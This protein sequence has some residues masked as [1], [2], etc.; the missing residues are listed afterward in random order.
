MTSR[1]ILDYIFNKR[2]VLQDAPETNGF[3]DMQED[4]EKEEVVESESRSFPRLSPQHADIL[5][6]HNFQGL[7]PEEIA[8]VYRMSVHRVAEFIKAAEK[9]LEKIKDNGKLS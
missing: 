2:P 8:R 6:L 9:T 7:S 5:Y 4:L 1:R 3:L